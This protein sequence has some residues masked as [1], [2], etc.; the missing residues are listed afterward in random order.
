MINVEY[1]YWHKEDECWKVDVKSFLDAEKARRFIILCKKASYLKFI[2][3]SCDYPEDNE[4]IWAR[5]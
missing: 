1:A 5:I 4:Y 3:Y 2:G